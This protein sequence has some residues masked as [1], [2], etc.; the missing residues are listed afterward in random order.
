[1]APLLRTSVDT[2]VDGA[3]CGPVP[4]ADVRD[5]IEKLAKAGVVVL[6]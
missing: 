3:E 1:M 6:K 4:L 2:A 5:Y